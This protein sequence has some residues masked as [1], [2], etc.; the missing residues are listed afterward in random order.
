MTGP[1]L[2]RVV[3]EAGDFHVQ[4]AV[5]STDV[6]SFEQFTKF[7]FSLSPGQPA[8]TAEIRRRYDAGL[9]YRAGFA[10]RDNRRERQFHRRMIE[11]SA[12][13]RRLRD[14][15]AAAMH[16]DVDARDSRQLHRAPET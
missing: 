14:H 4:V 9:R 5:G 10:V 15:V 11:R 1:R 3:A 13:A 12:G 16:V 8:A 2:T 7:H 6:E